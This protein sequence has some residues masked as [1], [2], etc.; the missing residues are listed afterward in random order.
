MVLAVLRGLSRGLV[1]L[2]VAVT[3]SSCFTHRSMAPLPDETKTELRAKG[4]EIGAPIFVRVFKLENEMEVWLRNVTGQYTHFRT[5]PI[6]N[7]SGKLGPKL[8]EG[9]KQAPEGFY[10]VNAT[11]MNPNSKFHLSFNMGFPNAYDKAHG[12]TGS[13]LMVH[14]GCRSIGCYAITDDA[15]TELFILAREA[16]TKGQRDFP[17]A[18]FPFRLTD[19]R[20]AQ[21][22]SHPWIDFWRNLKSGYDLFEA[23]R[24]PPIAGV[25][26][27]RYVFFADEQSIPPE[28]HALLTK[29]QAQSPEQIQLILG[30]N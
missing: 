7:W 21:S 28:Q 24:R 2:A 4:L 13:H 20:L 27:G 30:W 22:Q 16:F 26:N 18:A 29:E 10:V 11:Q 25:Q 17:I 14:G 1:L 15:I 8:K 9:D 19:H 5:Y 12:H 3:L 23:N 6:C